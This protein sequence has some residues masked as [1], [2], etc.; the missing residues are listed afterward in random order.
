MPPETLPPGTTVIEPPP[1]E[2]TDYQP[3]QENP[4]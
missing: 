3:G 1:E 4:E 2:P